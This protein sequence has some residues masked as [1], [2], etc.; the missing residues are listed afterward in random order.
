MGRPGVTYNDVA[1]AAEQL[2]SQGRNPTIESVRAAIGSGSTATIGPYLR[3]WRN[4]QDASRQVAMKENL[5][6]E[7][8]S[9]VKGLWERV[10]VDAEAKFETERIEIR[11]ALAECE[12]KLSLLQSEYNRAQQQIRAVTEEKLALTN[13]KLSLDQTVE[14]FQQRQR[15]IIDQKNGLAIKFEAQTTRIDEL[16][17]MHS[18]VQKNLEHYREASLVQRSQDQQA[19]EKQR[20]QLEQIIQ[21]ARHE[22]LQLQ[23]QLAIAQQQFIG[24]KKETDRLNGLIKQVKQNQ[25]ATDKILSETK[26]ELLRRTHTSEHWQQQYQALRA[27]AEQDERALRDTQA[28][29]FEDNAASQVMKGIGL[30]QKSGDSHETVFSRQSVPD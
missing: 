5:P 19:H 17:Q 27:R 29:R 23:H 25:E 4:K 13:E 3:A 28:Q 20:H 2:A 30:E 16:H 24:E 7:L 26:D 11:Q 22:T 8:I 6:E 18:Q 10:F 14:R 9:V 12:Q 21:Q 15:E 1:M